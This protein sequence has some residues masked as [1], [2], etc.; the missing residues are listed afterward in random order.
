MVTQW[1]CVEIGLLRLTIVGVSKLSGI[2]INCD[3]KHRRSE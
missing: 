2:L 1:V 3:T